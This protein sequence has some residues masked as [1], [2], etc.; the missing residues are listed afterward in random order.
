MDIFSYYF[1]K[2]VLMFIWKRPK[3]NEKEAGNGPFFK[4]KLT[5]ILFL[6]IKHLGISINSVPNLIKFRNFWETTFVYCALSLCLSLTLPYTKSPLI[7]ICHF[8]IF[9]S[10]LN[11]VMTNAAGQIKWKIKMKMADLV[12]E[13]KKMMFRDL[14]KYLV[15]ICQIWFHFVVFE[16]ASNCIIIPMS[17]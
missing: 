12:W 17:R 14:S 5:Q 8:V 16:W 9:Y 1:C 15:L 13:I 10:A 7:F 3:I 4:K 2:I 11:C 6:I